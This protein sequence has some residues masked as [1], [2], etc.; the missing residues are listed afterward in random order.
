MVELTEDSGYRTIITYIDQFSLMV[1]LVPLCETD[2]QTVASCFLAE[3]MSLHGL[4][5]TIISYRDPSF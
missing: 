5:A 2:T 4:I 1:L 3:V